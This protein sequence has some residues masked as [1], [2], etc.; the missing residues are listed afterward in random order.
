MSWFKRKKRAY[1]IAV[2]YNGARD[3]MGN[4]FDKDEAMRYV[5]FYHHLQNH[6]GDFSITIKRVYI[7]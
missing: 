3:I 7:K 4:F 2:E 6:D 5:R 1:Q